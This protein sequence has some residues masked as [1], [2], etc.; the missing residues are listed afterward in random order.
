MLSTGNKHTDPA[1]LGR[2]Q[3]RLKKKVLLVTAAPNVFVSRSSL[4]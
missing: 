1:L 3:N 4:K 2:K